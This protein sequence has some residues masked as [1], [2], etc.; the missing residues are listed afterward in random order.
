MAAAELAREIRAAGAGGCALSLAGGSTPRRAYELLAAE[1]GVAW[2]RVD[3]Y[4]GDERAVRPDD[5]Q[6][7]Y[8]MV[9]EALLDRLAGGPRVHRMEAEAADLDAAARR[10]EEQLPDR[11]DLLVLG[12]GPDGHTASLFPGSPALHEAR[13][14]VVPV[15]APVSPPRRLTITPPVIAAARLVIVIVS[16]ADKAASVARALEDE[17]DVDAVPAALA[18]EGLWL[19]DRAAAGRLATCNSE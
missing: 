13:R 19:L 7:N 3:V 8:R 12:M 14:R 6:S 15:E 5:P 16:G 11:L 9:R 10:Y 2:D 18:R 1:G 4:F 17:P